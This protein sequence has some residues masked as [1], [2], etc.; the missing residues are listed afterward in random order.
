[1]GIVPMWA[2][3]LKFHSAFPSSASSA[4]K[5]PSLLDPKNR[6]PPVAITPD[7]DPK[8]D[9]L[10]RESI[11]ALLRDSLPWVESEQ[12]K[13]LQDSLYAGASNAEI[14]LFAALRG[15]SRSISELSRYLGIS[16]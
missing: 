6:P 3:V 12:L 14:K 5:L 15:T 4:K 10:L 8:A 13:L 16:R 2:P 7:T 9:P 1:M 11:K